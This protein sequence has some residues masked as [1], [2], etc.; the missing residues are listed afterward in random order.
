MQHIADWRYKGQ[1]KPRGKHRKIKSKGS[2]HTSYIHCPLVG[3]GH[4][5]SCRVENVEVF[6]RILQLTTG[7]SW[8]PTVTLKNWWRSF[9]VRVC[10][11]AFSTRRRIM[12]SQRIT[13]PQRITRWRRTTPTWRGQTL[14][15]RRRRS[16]GKRLKVHKEGNRKESKNQRTARDLERGE[17]KIQ[18][19]G[20]RE[21]G[22]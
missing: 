3:R 16:H 15:L 2:N 1:L 22:V 7:K 18:E 19:R 17:R 20:R 12:G 10:R 5:Q 6:P 8:R 14:A 21:K 9:L 4:T 13:G 11:N